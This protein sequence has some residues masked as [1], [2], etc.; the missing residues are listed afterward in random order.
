MKAA[1]Q[2][3]GTKEFRNV[4][5]APVGAAA[6]QYFFIT[7]TNQ[8]ILLMAKVICHRAAISQLIQTIALD[9]PGHRD[10]AGIKGNSIPQIH[11]C[12]GGHQIGQILQPRVYTNVL[13]RAVIKCPNSWTNI[14]IENITIAKSIVHPIF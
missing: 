6:E 12:A 14:I 10:A 8:Q 13:F 5:N 4:Q 9:A 2:H 7:L 11:L 3:I 1:Y